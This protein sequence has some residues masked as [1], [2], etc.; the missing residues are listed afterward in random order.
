MCSLLAALLSN[1]SE[2]SVADASATEPDGRSTPIQVEQL[3]L[4]RIGKAM[5]LPPVVSPIQA[6]RQQLLFDTTILSPPPSTSTCTTPSSLPVSSHIIGTLASSFSTLMSPQRRRRSTSS[7]NNVSL[8]TAVVTSPHG[9]YN[10]KW[11]RNNSPQQAITDFEGW[12]CCITSEFA[13]F[14]V[15]DQFVM[16]IPSNHKNDTKQG[17]LQRKAL[18]QRVVATVSTCLSSHDD[19]PLVSSKAPLC[20]QPDSARLKMAEQH[21]ILNHGIE[22]RKLKYIELCCSIHR[23]PHHDDFVRDILPPDLSQKDNN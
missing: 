12:G 21:L 1:V 20:K 14:S 11:R 13:Q 4:V 17:I 8:S 2:T 9:G 18:Q 5:S 7:S 15:G 6:S 16:I 22:R 23:Y 19:T 3:L 10:C